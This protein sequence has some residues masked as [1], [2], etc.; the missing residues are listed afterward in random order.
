MPSRGKIP[1]A[2][3]ERANGGVEGIRLFEVRQMSRAGNDNELAFGNRLMKSADFLYVRERVLL[4]ADDQ[5]GNIGSRL[6]GSGAEHS[7]NLRIGD[8]GGT[9]LARESDQRFPALL[10]LPVVGSRARVGENQTQYATP[11]ASPESEAD[12]TT[13]RDAGD[14]RRRN[15]EQVEQLG[16]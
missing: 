9:F 1:N 16:D 15:F 7:D 2:P 12:V 3:E 6:P 11:V 14:H 5:R 10:C 8:R 4:S 13:H